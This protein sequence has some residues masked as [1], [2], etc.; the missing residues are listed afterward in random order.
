MQTW[1][2]RSPD[3]YTT[4]GGY[5]VRKGGPWFSVVGPRVRGPLS[6]L[7]AAMDAVFEMIKERE[8]NH[9]GSTHNR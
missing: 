4:K 9:V 6:S 3:R 5:V 7:D 8:V 2:A 1:F